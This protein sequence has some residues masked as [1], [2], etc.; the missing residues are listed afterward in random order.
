[1]TKINFEFQGTVHVGG[2]IIS[3]DSD[4]PD[5]TLNVS[6]DGQ[7][8]S[9]GC[10][11]AEIA[12]AVGIKNMVSALDHDEVLS[13]YSMDDFTDHLINSDRSDSDIK[14]LSI[15]LAKSLE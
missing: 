3:S 11:D 2:V 5:H 14:Q 1:M 8:V 10:V 6:L 7:V 15:A 4:S 12:R 13:H 9:G